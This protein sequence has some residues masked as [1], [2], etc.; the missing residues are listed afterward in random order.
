[1]TQNM[2]AIIAFILYQITWHLFLKKH[3]VFKKEKE[4]WKKILSGIL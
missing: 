2:H 3:F 4:F 1:M